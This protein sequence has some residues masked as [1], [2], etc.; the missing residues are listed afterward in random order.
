MPHIKQYAYSLDTTAFGLRDAKAYV[1]IF[2][3]LSP[4]SF[5]YIE[6]LHAQISEN[7]ESGSIPIIVVGNKTDKVHRNLSTSRMRNRR[8]ERE[9][10]KKAQ[11]G[12]Y[13]ILDH[14]IVR[15]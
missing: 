1:F 8:Q 4:D 10:W 15:S 6:G 11:R 12:N 13:T 5:D 7:R 2:D 14:K 3:L 9:E